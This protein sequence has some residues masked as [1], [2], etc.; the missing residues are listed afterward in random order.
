MGSRL[1]ELASCVQLNSATLPEVINMPLSDLKTYVTSLQLKHPS[2]TEEIIKQ[3][4]NRIQF[5]CEVGLPYMSIGRNAPS[6]SGG[7]AQRIR[8]ARQLGSALSGT[9]YILDEPSIG[10]HPHNTSL[11]NSALLMLRDLG[12][13][14]IIVEHE[15][16]MIKIAD[17]IVDF[18]PGSGSE[19]G[20]ILF[21]GTPSEFYSSSV[22]LTSQ[23]VTGA[24]VI[25]SALS[26]QKFTKAKSIHIRDA[27]THNLKSISCTIPLSA[28]SVVTGVSG[29][30]KSSLV[31]NFL[32]KAVQRAID[33]NSTESIILNDGILEH[34]GFITKLLTVDQ[35]P[36]GLTNRA[37]I[38]TFVDLL[39]PIR[40]LYASLPDA[41]IRGLQAYNFSFNHLKGMCRECWGIGNKTIT[42]P[43]MAPITIE[44]EGCKGKRLNPLAL[45]VQYKGYSLGDLFEIPLKELSTILPLDRK[46]EKI[47][48]VMEEVGLSYLKL[49]QHIAT[50]SGGESQRIKLAKALTKQVHSKT[51]L[52]LDEPT[53]GL[54]FEDIKKLLVVI[55]ALIKKKA[56]VVVIEH[57]LDFMSHADYVIDMGHGGG[58][59][60]GSIIY[61][62]APKQLLKVENSLTG[63]YL[64]KH[65]KQL[66][67]L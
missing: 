29:C 45:Q 37:D 57:N 19:G 21:S 11:L 28:L 59:L 33:S 16:D 39:T 51:L 30:G 9:L 55:K 12:N 23:Y 46:L 47:F 60:G 65:L 6:L 18:G 43:F 62:G 25:A 26:N 24:K 41:K 54:H 7:E 1:N 50:L 35:S 66:D 58:A 36:V 52:I 48:S 13:T 49:G 53:T 61:E 38:S 27:T 8:L 32:S 34:S 2:I 44:C 3:V 56:T 42:V 15:T 17:T 5:L 67:L 31:Y 14:L 40:K 20:S 4:T 63:K 64:Q 10:L 22:S